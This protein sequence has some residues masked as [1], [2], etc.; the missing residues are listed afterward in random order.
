MTIER[1]V[2]AVLF[3]SRRILVL[4]HLVLVASLLALV[5]M[6]GRHAYEIAIHLPDVSESDLI[7]S[8]LGLVDLTLT[9]SLV[10]IVVY[11]GYSNFVSRIDA[12]SHEDWPQWMFAIDFNQLKLKVMAAIVAISAVKLLESFMDVGK[13]TDRELMWEGGLHA[14][15]VVSLLGMAIADRVGA[16]RGHDGS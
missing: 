15:F 12:A 3:A 7:V 11:S 10:L 16:G 4:F 13:V 1:A 14:V 5:V 9:A 8:I 6:L 2:E